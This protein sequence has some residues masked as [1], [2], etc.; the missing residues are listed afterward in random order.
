MISALCV[1]IIVTALFT[2]HWSIHVGDS[3]QHS[4]EI[5]KKILNCTFECDHNKIII[6]YEDWNSSVGCVFPSLSCF[7][8]HRRFDTL[9]N[10]HLR[11]FFPWS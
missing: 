3:S 2:D 11:R 9:V 6:S 8:Q 10:F 1:I 4:E 5:V 7:M